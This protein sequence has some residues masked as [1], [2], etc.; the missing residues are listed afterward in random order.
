M[1]R[2]S[3]AFFSAR[4]GFLHRIAAV[5]VAAL[6]L[7]GCKPEAIP[8]PPAEDVGEGFPPD[9]AG[10]RL[11]Y[12]RPDGIYLRTAAKPEAEKIVGDAAYPRWA[13]DGQSF[14]F[15]RGNRVMLYR[16]SD[17]SARE[18]AVAEKGRAVAFHPGGGEVW[19][20]DGDA[21]KAVSVEGGASRVALSGARVLELDFAPDGTFLAATVPALGG[22]RVARFEL[23]GGVRRDI[24]R[25]CSAGV[26]ADGGRILVNLD[27]HTRL[28]L[29]DATSGERVA[30]IAAPPGFKLDNQKWSNHPDW[31]AAVTEG[32]RQDIVI[33][34]ASDGRVWRVTS[35]GDADRPDLR[36]E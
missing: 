7:F 16:F 26:T 28:A 10:A 1:I 11:L 18:L 22:Y 25:G 19:F 17:R 30:E 4:R 29:F 20:T 8:A 36:V 24:A 23:P 33:Q 15:L 21:V 35:E 5:G 14:A 13:P 6:A 9:L 31:L 27:G 3:S 34:R 2:F 32:R 12:Q